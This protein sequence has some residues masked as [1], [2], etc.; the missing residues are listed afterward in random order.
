[1]AGIEIEKADREE[2]AKVLR[3]HL[4]TEFD[5][6]LGGID[7]E[8]LLDFITE[9]FGPSF[10]NQGLLD[11]QAVVSKRIDVVIEAIDELHKATPRS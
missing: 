11:A 4:K 1:M 6:E 3:H 5:V 8:F 10:Y 7:A 9:R 2:M